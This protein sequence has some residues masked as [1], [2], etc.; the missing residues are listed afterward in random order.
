MGGSLKKKRG[1]PRIGGRIFCRHGT[2]DN[3]R[4]LFVFLISKQNKKKNRD[5]HTWNQDTS[6]FVLKNRDIRIKSG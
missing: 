5:F 1:I 6:R 3:V 2:C 4:C